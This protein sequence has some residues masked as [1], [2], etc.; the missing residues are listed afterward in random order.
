MKKETWTN[1]VIGLLCGGAIYFWEQGH[2]SLSLP[3][4]I[5]FGAAIGFLV[6]FIKNLLF[7][8]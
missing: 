8:K 6:G 7:K 4:A 5:G 3:Q 1:I 2:A